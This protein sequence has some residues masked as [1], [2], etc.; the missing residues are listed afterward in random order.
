MKVYYNVE[1]QME[2][3]N[4][5]NKDLLSRII[6]DL[7]AGDSD[8]DECEDFRATLFF[9]TETKPTEMRNKIRKIIQSFE[10]KV[11]YIDVIYRFEAEMIPDRFVF[12]ANGREQE[13]IGEVIFTEEK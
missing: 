6:H 10:D 9:K 11:H 12:W 13:Y 7:G 4:H 1:I 8:V 3:F 2:G 5:V